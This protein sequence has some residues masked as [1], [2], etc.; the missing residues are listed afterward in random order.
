M[1]I[2]IIQS[3]LTGSGFWGGVLLA[4]DIAAGLAACGHHVVAAEFRH[5]SGPSI[6]PLAGF[7]VHHL[8]A[9]PL[10]HG[11][12]PLWAWQPAAADVA[13]AAR[14]LNN[15]AA[16]VVYG[17]MPYG[18]TAL[19]EAAI[20]LGIP[21]VHH[22][23]DFSVLCGRSFL[24]D[25]DG[26]PCSGPTSIG[27]CEACLRATQPTVIQLGM[28]LAAFPLGEALLSRSLGSRRTE[29]FRL[30]QGV[31]TH[32]AFRERLIDGV[33]AW[34]ATG[35]PVRDVLCRYGVPAERITLLP[36]ALPEDRLVTSP[37][38]PPLVGRPLRIGFFGRIAPE[39]GVDLLAT[40]L[41]RLRATEPRDLE[42][43]VISG[44]VS[45]AERQRLER[46]SGLPADRIRFIEGLRGAAINPV[47][48]QLD[49]CVIPS[50]W[51]EIG[52][53]TLLEALAQ[54]V[55]CV[56]NDGAG[57]ADLI[58]P[59]VNGFR[60]RTGDAADLTATLATLLRDDALVARLR[61]GSRRI[62]GFDSFVASIEAIL[63]ASMP[64]GSGARPVPATN[65]D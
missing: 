63:A 38:P 2:A 16:D 8:P 21:I 57:H 29:R 7:A 39:K 12:N 41:R 11:V 62:A 59:G 51:P 4:R 13:T 40:A 47:V 37:P 19:Y 6:T 58:E 61:T 60:F 65:S 56:C 26:Q 1:N 64:S 55:P 24:V 45:A 46:L 10:T 18:N 42:W 23:H 22:V 27:K 31:A 36:H 53:L 5:D 52:P 14:F 35:Q 43:W 50:L 33:T 3:H 17:H 15:C 44:S 34:I 54:G 48:A 25:N 30:R 9:E 28:R 49:V 32:A 20:R